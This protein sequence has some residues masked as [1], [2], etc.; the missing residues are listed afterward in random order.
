MRIAILSSEAAPYSKTG[1]LGDVAGALPKALKKIGEDVCLITPFY[2]QTS[3]DLI[4]GVAIP[5]MTF[6]WRGEDVAARIL[7]SDACGAPTFLVDH[8]SQFFRDSIYGYGED[9]ERFAFFSRAALV[10]L[11]S[12]GNPPDIVHLN[13]WHTGFA[14]AELNESRNFDHFFQKTK[15]IFSIHNMAYQGIFDPNELWKIGFGSEFARSSF[16]LNGAASALKAGLIASDWLSTVSPRYAEEI[17][18]SEYGFGLE[19]LV[20]RRKN[21]LLGITNGIDYEIWNPANDTLIPANYSLEDMTG[22]EICKK[23]LLEKF[24]LPV[25]TDRPVIASISRLTA[26]KGIELIMQSVADLLSS[27]AYIIALG[28]GEKRYEDFWQSLRDYAPRQVGV[29]IGYNEE[30]SHLIEAGADIFLMPSK[31]EPCGLNQMYSLR[32]GTIPVVRDV[33]GLHD[34]VEDWN[35]VELTGNGFKF[36]NYSGTAMIEKVYEAIYAWADTDSLNALRRNG[37]AIDNSWENSARK[38]CGLY[39]LAARG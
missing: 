31:F 17:Q 8:Q 6:K 30:L 14:A 2:R 15:I 25:N 22:K 28:S 10:L 11:R 7:Y 37:M 34:T 38:Y 26:Q 36:Q 13:D 32:Y 27:G 19:W 9:Y 23:A 16:A 21:R 24:S 12:L 29:F 5:Q 39:Q 35:P 4:K 18:S 1:G 20:S 33:G 3:P